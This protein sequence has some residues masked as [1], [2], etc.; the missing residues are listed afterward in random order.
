M[1]SFEVGD[2]TTRVREPGR[3]RWGRKRDARSGARGLEE[4]R[5][6]REK[7]PGWK[8]EGGGAAPRVGERA[9]GPG[10]AVPPGRLQPK[11]RSEPRVPEGPPLRTKR[12]GVLE[13]LGVG[14]VGRGGGV[15]EENQ[16][17][18][19]RETREPGDVIRGSFAKGA[20]SNGEGGR[21][22][23]W[24]SGPAGGCHRTSLLPEGK[25]TEET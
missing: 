10:E 8:P 12:A 6:S 9:Q 15:T 24:P 16:E 22:E 3:S 5:G 11:R 21:W 20:A 4:L 23:S 25:I 17:I 1:S 7:L 2:T 14:G 13:D 18:K 19:S